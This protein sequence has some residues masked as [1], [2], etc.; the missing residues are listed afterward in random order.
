[1]LNGLHYFISSDIIRVYCPKV[2]NGSV[3][4]CFH[5]SKSNDC[6]TALFTNFNFAFN[7]STLQDRVCIGYAYYLGQG[8]DDVSIDHFF[9]LNLWHWMTLMITWC[10]SNISCFT[11]T[12]KH[13]L[14]HNS[15][16]ENV[17][18]AVLALNTV[19]LQM[20]DHD[21]YEFQFIR[22]SNCQTNNGWYLLVLSLF[23]LYIC[24]HLCD[25]FCIWLK[26]CLSHCSVI[27]LKM[28]RQ[29]RCLQ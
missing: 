14:G 5:S 27:Q 8:L 23:H 28:T 18:E 22:S 3:L 1:M 19:V 24:V 20:F 12:K 16:S 15:L 6:V 17:F 25:I 2:V 26:L 21:L 13:L 7:V 10:F 9:T 4:F 29:D 11:H